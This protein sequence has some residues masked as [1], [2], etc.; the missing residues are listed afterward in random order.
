M[1]L[2]PQH[3]VKCLASSADIKEQQQNSACCTQNN[4]D[5]GEML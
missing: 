5:I 2:N 3:L 4:R 1:Y